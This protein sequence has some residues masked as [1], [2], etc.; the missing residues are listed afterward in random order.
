MTDYPLYKTCIDACLYCASVCNLCSSACTQEMNVK[1]MTKSIQLC[2]ECAIIC[3]ATAQLMSLGSTK[4][5]AMFRLCTNLC[6]ACANECAKHE[7][8]H[9]QECTAACRRCAA[10]CRRLIA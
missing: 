3:Y 2:M 9:C 5:K 7:I 6:E 1:I 10:E 8:D 4:T